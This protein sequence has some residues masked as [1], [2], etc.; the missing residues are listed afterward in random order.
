MLKIIVMTTNISLVN[1]SFLQKKN[2]SA[3]TMQAFLQSAKCVL[4]IRK[5][6]GAKTEYWCKARESQRIVD[7]AVVAR[8]PCGKDDFQTHPTC[9]RIEG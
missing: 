1:S 9:H 4:R 6:R 2:I 5:V 7:S 3:E 8:G